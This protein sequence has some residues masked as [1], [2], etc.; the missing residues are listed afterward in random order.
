ETWRTSADSPPYPARRSSDLREDSYVS[1]ATGH[2]GSDLV[3]IIL[4][5]GRVRRADA[6]QEAVGGTDSDPV[7]RLVLGA[8]REREDL[9]L[10]VVREAERIVGEGRPGAEPTREPPLSGEVAAVRSEEQR[11]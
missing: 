7:A 3:P 9:V 10:A 4:I 2:V 8:E 5:G 11:V 6:I 1:V